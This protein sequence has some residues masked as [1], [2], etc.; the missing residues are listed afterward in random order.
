MRV[1]LFATLGLVLLL[2][3]AL[4]TGC[5]PADI[6]EA[7]DVGEVENGEAD[8][9]PFAGQTLVVGTWSGPYAESMVEAIFEPF[10]ELTGVNIEYK[11]AWDHTPEILAAPENDPPMDVTITAQ[12][13]F[14]HGK[15]QELWL[16]LRYENIPNAAE[17][18]QDL[19]EFMGPWDDDGNN[20]FGVPFDL[21]IHCLFY[22]KDLVSFEPTSWMDLWNEEFTDKI[23]LENYYPYNLYVGAFLADGYEGADAVYTKEGQ[24]ALITALQK[25]NKAQGC[26]W[27]G[28]GAELVAALEAEEVLVSNYWG[29]SALTTVLESPDKYAMVYP[30]EGSAAY[31]DYW[32]VVRGTAKQDLAEYFINYTLDPEVQARFAAI[33]CQVVSGKNIITPSHMEGYYPVT[34]EDWA[35]ILFLDVEFLEPYRMELDERMTR[36]VLTQ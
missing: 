3:F 12:P 15:T 8:E 29:G 23:M 6:P 2:G 25:M 1:K 7:G 34:D 24:D 32:A 16:P 35:K 4:F 30:D 27:Y 10:E 21:A 19:V 13:D 9:Q 18:R 14:L 33:Q 17:V 22:R 26:R 5:T 11:V 20:T 36:E 31:L 28:G